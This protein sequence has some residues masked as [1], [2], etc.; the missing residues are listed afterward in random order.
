MLKD[1]LRIMFNNFERFI[2]VFFCLDIN[3][4]IKFDN[5]MVL[6]DDL[7]EVINILFFFILF[8][9]FL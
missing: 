3:D 4:L 6:R 8:L 9:F 5:F 2:G 1:L 7:L